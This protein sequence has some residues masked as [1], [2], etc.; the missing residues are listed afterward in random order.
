MS[1]L[2]LSRLQRGVESPK[3]FLREAN[4]L[5]HRRLYTRPYNTAGIDVFAEDWDNLIIL[6]ACRY[7]MFRDQADLPGQLYSRI[8]RGSSTVEFLRANFAET[9]LLDTVYVTANPQLY[10]HRDEMN[11]NLHAT[12]EVWSEDGWDE[13]KKTVLPEVMA[14]YTLDAAERFPNKRLVSHFIQPHYPFLFDE[15][16]FDDSQAFLRPEEAGSWHQVMTGK[17]SVSAEAVW[18]AYRATL[19]RALPSVERLL[20]ELPGRTVVTADHGNMIGERA[21]PIPI[22]EWGHPRGVYTEELVEIPWFVSE[23]GNRPEIVAEATEFGGKDGDRDV[24]TERLQ[25]LGYTE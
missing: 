20:A 4:R 1:L 11:P 5:Y 13:E 10:R 14:Q 2:S 18:R 7:D 6:D 25:D 8:S 21:R 19:N 16:V 17:L 15:E 23:G 12:V 9:D 24:V 22:Q 3:L